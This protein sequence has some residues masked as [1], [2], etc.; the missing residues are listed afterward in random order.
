MKLAKPFSQLSRECIAVC[1]VDFPAR[2][3]NGPDGQ[4]GGEEGEKEF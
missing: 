3:A 2:K 4:D 1:A